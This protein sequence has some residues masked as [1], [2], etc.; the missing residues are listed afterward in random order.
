MIPQGPFYEVTAGRNNVP[1][2]GN[3]VAAAV[4]LTWQEIVAIKDPA[5]GKDN[6]HLAP[7]DPT[8]PYLVGSPTDPTYG[9]SFLLPGFPPPVP[10]VS[11]LEAEIAQLKA[12]LAQQPP[13]SAPS[14]A[15]QFV[16]FA[17]KVF[18]GLS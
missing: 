3:A 4:G 5:T 7:Y 8:G 2:Y 12:Q 6:A 18:P 14:D 15:D 10:D 9:V 13:A 16:T 11:A 17:K 1:A